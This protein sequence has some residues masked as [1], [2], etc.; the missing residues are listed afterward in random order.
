MQKNNI[1]LLII[2]SL[3]V[4]TGLVCMEKNMLPGMQKMVR[5]PCSDDGTYELE[6]WKVRES[7]SLYTHCLQFNKNFELI[8]STIEVPKIPMPHETMKLF[9]STLDI[10]P[11]KLFKEYFFNVLMPKQQQTLIIAAGLVDEHGK[12]QFNA[13]ALT[14]QIV[15]AYF[16]EDWRDKHIKPLLQRVHWLEYCFNKVVNNNVTSSFFPDPTFFVK[17]HEMMEHENGKLSA[18]PS[19]L[20]VKD[21]LYDGP[22]RAVRRPI[23]DSHWVVLRSKKIDNDWEHCITCFEA[24]DSI[25][26]QPD[27]KVVIWAINNSNKDITKTVVEHKDAMLQSFFSRDGKY[28]VTRSK[29]DVFVSKIMHKE[30]GSSVIDTYCVGHDKYI[31]DVCYGH[32]SNRLIV[33]SSGE[34][35]GGKVKLLDIS[36]TG[37]ACIEGCG[38]IDKAVLS[39]NGDKLL[40]ISGVDKKQLIALYKVANYFHH[41]K[42]ITIPD[43]AHLTLD[44]V[45]CSPNGNYWALTTNNGG[46]LFIPTFGDQCGGVVELVENSVI[47]QDRSMKV[48]FSSDSRFLISLV[49]EALKEPMIEVW[50]TI[51]GEK[52]VSW[53]SFISKDFDCGIGLTPNH[54]ELVLFSNDQFIY[55]RPFFREDDDRILSHLFSSTTVYG[56]SLLR[57]LYLA[58]K[59][60]ENIELYEEE[61]AYKALINMQQKPLDVAAFVK[62]YLS[63]KVIDNKKGAVQLLQETWKNFSF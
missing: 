35:Y 54:R 24:V 63:W 31:M 61:P 42:T 34:N 5:M 59:N 53:N 12:R 44:R 18:V 39:P 55:K 7:I 2:L 27:N 6:K 62:K 10:V 4:S 60:K 23:Q 57:R 36:G 32:Q 38:F 8:D 16:N 25:N 13:P 41:Y 3:I 29:E 33:C 19:C 17:E 48:L 21:S 11:G 58:N 52:I 20:A 43:E 28:V 45:V 26:E 37:I 47:N 49:Q 56:L 46:L 15:D 51:N 22:C 1:V 40:I 9:S 50:S 30:D 14:A